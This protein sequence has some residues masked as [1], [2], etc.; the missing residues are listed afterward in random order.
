MAHNGA[1]TPVALA[2]IDGVREA[3]GALCKTW[4][5]DEHAPTSSFVPSLNH[6]M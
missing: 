6:A 1:G 5:D 4:H 2:L 3:D